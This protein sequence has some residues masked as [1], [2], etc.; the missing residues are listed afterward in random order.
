MQFSALRAGASIDLNGAIGALDFN[1]ATGEAPI[2]YEIV[3]FGTDD[4]GRATSTAEGAGLVYEGGPK[5]LTGTL[6]C[7]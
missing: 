5:K 7:P 6:R 2:D 4:Q 3:C 1:P